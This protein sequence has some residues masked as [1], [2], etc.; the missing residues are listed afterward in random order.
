MKKKIQEEFYPNN[1]LNISN[2]D[3][4]YKIKSEALH[5]LLK[6]KILKSQEIPEDL[7][8]KLNKLLSLPEIPIIT[9]DNY[10]LY[11]SMF[12]MLRQSN[13]N[14]ILDNVLKLTKEF[15]KDKRFQQVRNITKLDSE[16]SSVYSYSLTKNFL[17]QLIQEL[18]KQL[19]K[20]QQQNQQNQGGQG[21][22]NPQAQ[23][24]QQ[25]LDML[26]KPSSNPQQ[27]MQQI[28]QALQQALQNNQ[29]LQKAFQEAYQNAQKQAQRDTRNAKNLK[30]FFGEKAGK[31]KGS[32]EKLI[33]LTEAIRQVKGAEKIISFA[34]KILSDMPIFTKI[35]K[36]QSSFGETYGYKKTRN[37]SKA[38]P[39]ELAIDELFDLKYISNGFLARDKRITAQGNFLVLLDK[40]GSMDSMVKKV[41]SRSVALALYKIA[42]RKKLK[43]ALIFF[44]SEP[45]DPITQRNEII[46][47]LL[48]IKPSGGTA[49]D[50]AIKKAF[51]FLR[52]N[53][54]FSNTIIVIT[55]GQDTV[56]TSKEDLAKLNIHLVSVMID[57]HNGTLENISEKYLIAQ[58]DENG[59]LRLLDIASKEA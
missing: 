50:E 45:Y 44:D 57:G 11:Y 49:I 41:W 18:Q 59:A 51:E 1:L 56:H 25:L 38:I 36:V 8:V 10:F 22:P 53:K 47:S 3:S 7:K 33:D 31:E 26:S 43:Y 48:K 58:L 29:A 40:S 27:Q 5:K 17:I 52:Q 16:L 24:I 13:P 14:N 19:Q 35:Q 2:R 12:P 37:I 46:D 42:L 54:G 30:D 55:D 4:I 32:L 39:K 20:Q 9:A 21:Q 15:K 23:Q 6:S 28:Q 34:N